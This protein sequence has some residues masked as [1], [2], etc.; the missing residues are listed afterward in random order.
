MDTSFT[1][2]SLFNTWCPNC[3]QEGVLF[4]REEEKTIVTSCRN[5][6]VVSISAYRPNPI[7]N[8]SKK[9][10]DPISCRGLARK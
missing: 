6:G 4:A 2:P 9:L 5:C 10:F 3:E 7:V 1:H 8:H